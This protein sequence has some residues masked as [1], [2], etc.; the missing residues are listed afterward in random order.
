MKIQRIWILIWILF[1]SNLN[2]PQSKPDLS[3]C[4]F[5][6]V[7]EREYRVTIFFK[8][9]LQSR[10]YKYNELQIFPKK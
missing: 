3:P 5:D 1:V 7:I 8:D 2:E 6:F 9:Y 4:K 10:S